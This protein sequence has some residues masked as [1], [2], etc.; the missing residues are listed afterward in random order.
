MV[1]SFKRIHVAA[2]AHFPSAVIDIAKRKA[3]E[4]EASENMVHIDS[5]IETKRNRVE[6]SMTAFKN[7]DV[8][9]LQSSN[10][11]TTLSDIVDNP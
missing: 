10:I 6:I 1:L 7:C 8:S 9:S 11:R 3:E 5:S 2:M 4:L